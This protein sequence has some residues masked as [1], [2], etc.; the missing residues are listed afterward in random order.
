MKQ[1][2]VERKILW[3]DLDALGIVFYPRYSEWIDASSH[4]FFEALNLNLGNLWQERKIIF[5]LVEITCRYFK[6]GRYLQTIRIVTHIHELAKKTFL[7]KHSIKCSEENTLMAEGF[8]KRICVDTSDPENLRAIDIPD[9]IYA[10]LE[11]AKFK[12]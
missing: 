1:N 8:E 2:V 9:D 3:G 7:L 10:I 4:L 5:S 11:E 12:Y 6:P